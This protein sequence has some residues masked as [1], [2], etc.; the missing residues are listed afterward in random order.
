M[1]HLAPSTGREEESKNFYYSE[2]KYS[3]T[4]C[5]YNMVAFMLTSLGLCV[6]M[7]FFIFYFLCLY[8]CC[9]ATEQRKRGEREKRVSG[10]ASGSD[11]DSGSGSDSG[12]GG[13]DWEEEEEEKRER[14]ETPERPG[15][16]FHWR[17][18][19]PETQIPD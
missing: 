1:E 16:G 13:S 14:E 9:N 11:T 4:S 18:Q 15:E 12:S 17:L 5:T 7:G 10:S 2:G 8:P 19:R 3:T 6:A